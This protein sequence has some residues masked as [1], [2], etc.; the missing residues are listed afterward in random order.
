MPITCTVEGLFRIVR[1]S[2]C[3]QVT[4][5]GKIQNYF[6][7]YRN[8]YGHYPFEEGRGYVIE[9]DLIYSTNAKLQTRR[10]PL[11]P[12]SKTIKVEDL[13]DYQKAI[14]EAEGQK[15]GNVLKLLLDL[16]S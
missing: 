13:S 3:L 1:V 14:M 2:H 11:A 12:E 9:V 6:W 5:D 8:N 10:F 16:K 4:L 7:N 15:V